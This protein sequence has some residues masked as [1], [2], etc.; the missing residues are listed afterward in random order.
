MSQTQR[1]LVYTAAIATAWLAIHIGGIFFWRFSFATTPLVVLLVLV[2]AWLSTGLF[3]IAHDCMHGS[4]APGRPRVNRLVGTLSLAAY[5]GLSYAALLPK[6]QAHHARPGTP[7]DPDFHAPAP[8]NPLAWFVGFFRGYYSHAQLLRITLAAV[9]Y[10]LLGAS[11]VN[12]A[13]FWAVPAIIALM[14]LFF[15]GTFLPHRHDDHAFADHHNARSNGWSPALSLLTCFN[16]GAY[17]H[18]HHLNPGVP[19]W[20]LPASRRAPARP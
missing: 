4:L 5:A 19:W 20:Q 10:M 3:I 11:L 6:H 17:H 12:I 16:F 14:Q 13:V 8:R 1:S 7:D 18:E 15:F 2:Q 9:V